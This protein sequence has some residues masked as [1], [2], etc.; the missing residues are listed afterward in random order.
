MLPRKT[1]KGMKLFPGHIYSPGS[2]VEIE[3]EAR[4]PQIKFK[5]HKFNNRPRPETRNRTAIF[6]CFSE[7]GSEIVGCLYC[8]PKLMQEKYLGYYSVALGWQGRAFLYKHLVDEFWEIEPDCQY[9]RDYC[10]AFHHDSRNLRRVEKACHRSHGIL[11]SA[12]EQS[13]VAVKEIFPFVQKAK[14]NAAFPR[15]ENPKKLTEIAHFLHK[16]NMVGITARNRRC[17]GRNLDITFYEKLIYELEGM[18]YNPI[19]LGE[20]ATTHPCP[21]PHIPDFSTS[22]HALDLE[23]TLLLVSQLK[24]T[25]QFY[26]A[27]SRL[28]A[29]VG[30]PYIIVESPDQIWGVGQ[31]GIRLNLCTKGEKKLVIAHFKSLY[32]NQPKALELVAQAVGEIGAGNYNDIIGNVEDVKAIEFMKQQSIVRIGG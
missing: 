27:S 5:V 12:N 13:R 1:F 22:E 7:F 19:W 24:F 14:P 2:R 16:P 26:T 11:V 30:T 20:K 17:Y 25:I 3:K 29:L 21:C 8:I 6:S 31:E 4:L 10:R 32:E 28:A 18:G 15:I 23:K 9:L